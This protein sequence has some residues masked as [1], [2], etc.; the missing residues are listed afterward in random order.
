VRGVHVDEIR[1][2]SQPGE[3]PSFV[4]M[5]AASLRVL[6]GVVHLVDHLL[7]QR[8]GPALALHVRVLTTRAS[9]VGQLPPRRARVA[10]D[11]VPARPDRVEIGEARAS[12]KARG[13]RPPALQLDHCAPIVC[14]RVSRIES[15]LAPPPSSS[16]AGVTRAL[17]SRCAG[18]P[19]RVAVQRPHDLT[20]H[21]RPSSR[22]ATGAPGRA[23]RGGVWGA[24]FGAPHQKIR[25]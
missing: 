23:A 22:R 20:D 17:V 1:R 13:E 10:L 9:R 14:T 24:M 18:S 8:I 7:P 6:R 11:A 19:S 3:W 21:G 16:C 5:T 12:K 25:S 2:S 15:K 4:S